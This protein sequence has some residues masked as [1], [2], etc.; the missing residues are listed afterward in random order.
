MDFKKITVG[1][2]IQNFDDD[3][4]PLSQEFVA[5]DQVDYEDRYGT[6]IDAPENEQY[7]PFDMKQPTQT[8]PSTMR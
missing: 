4:T 7:L 1:F 3:G 8:I 6:P 5:G 2:V